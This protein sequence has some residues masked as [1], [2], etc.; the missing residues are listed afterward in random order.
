VSIG[1]SHSKVIVTE[2]RVTRARRYAAASL[3]FDNHS[4][5]TQPTRRFLALAG[6]RASSQVAH[7]NKNLIRMAPEE[8]GIC[9]QPERDVEHDL[10]ERGRIPTVERNVLGKIVDDPT[11][12]VRDEAEASAAEELNR[13]DVRAFE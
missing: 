10:V 9:N 4:F 1:D 11:G 8:S 2:D 12:L 5:D 3:E 13:K 7:R 6:N